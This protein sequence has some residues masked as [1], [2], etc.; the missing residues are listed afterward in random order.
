MHSPLRE[1]EFKL[2]CSFAAKTQ[3]PQSSLHMQG[4]GGGGGNPCGGAVLPQVA[5]QVKCSRRTPPRRRGRL[6]SRGGG[7]RGRGRR[8][9]FIAAAAGGVGVVVEGRLIGTG[10]V[11]KKGWGDEPGKK[12]EGKVNLLVRVKRRG[13]KGRGRRQR[14][15]RGREGRKEGGRAARKVRGVGRGWGKH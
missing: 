3:R 8:V 11:G 1:F 2:C 9:I 6:P 15:K 13:R 14:W 5:P 7:S 12:V 10:G 4:G